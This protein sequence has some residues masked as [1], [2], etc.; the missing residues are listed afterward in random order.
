MYQYIRVLDALPSCP[1]RLPCILPSAAPFA[2]TRRHG[3]GRPARLPVP[4]YY[5]QFLC[6][7]PAPHY[8]CPDV[9]C[10]AVYIADACL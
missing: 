9:L 7:R 6:L 5:T 3:L 8:P 10:R 4:T 1:V 2:G